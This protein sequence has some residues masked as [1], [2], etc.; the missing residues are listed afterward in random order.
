MIDIN[1]SRNIRK[2]LKGIMHRINVQN[3][4]LGKLLETTDSHFMQTGYSD[5]K[6]Q[7]EEVIKTLEAIEC[8]LHMA[9]TLTPEEII[10]EEDEMSCEQETVNA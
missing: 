7:L 1:R 3:H 8:H 10:A 2:A 6:Q 4:S 5:C 9:E